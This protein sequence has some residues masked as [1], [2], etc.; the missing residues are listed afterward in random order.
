MSRPDWASSRSWR[1]TTWLN[2]RA[3]KGAGHTEVASLCSLGLWVAV[4][5]SRG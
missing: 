4:E 2:S 3:P 1:P 5:L